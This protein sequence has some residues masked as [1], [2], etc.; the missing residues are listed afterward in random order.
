MPEQAMFI[1]QEL[2]TFMGIT[3]RPVPGELERR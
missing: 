3:D 2:E 1:E